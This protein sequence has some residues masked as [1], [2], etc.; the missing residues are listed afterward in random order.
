MAKKLASEG[1]KTTLIADSALT[2][3]MSRVNK[4]IVGTHAIMANGGL[5][6]HSG[7]Q[8]VSMVSQAFSIPFLVIAG[9]YKLTPMY[10]FDYMTFNELLSP[11]NIFKPIEGEDT[12]KVT[13]IVPQYDYVPP[14][15]VSLYVT[16]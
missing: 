10:P 15:S 3:L 12:S 1:I 11:E 8:L 14:E 6:T 16:N 5:V 2:A 9:L 7:T 4:V 13:A